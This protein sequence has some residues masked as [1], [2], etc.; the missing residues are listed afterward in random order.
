M[1]GSEPIRCADCKR[2]LQGDEDFCPQCGLPVKPARRLSDFEVGRIA[3]LESVK[4]DLW[5]RFRRWGLV[6]TIV[7]ALL[8]WVGGNAIISNAARSAVENR[9][10]M[11]ENRIEQTRYDLTLSLAHTEEANKRLG[12][13]SSK[14]KQEIENLRTKRDEIA[15]S[16]EEV[17]RDI[18]ILA[19]DLKEAV[20]AQRA[21]VQDFVG[22]ERRARLPSPC[23]SWPTVAN[24]TN[25]L[26]GQ[27]GT[28]PPTEGD[29]DSVVAVVRRY[30]ICD[31]Q[32]L[33]VVLASPRQAEVRELYHDILD[34]DPDIY[35]EIIWGWRLDHGFSKQQ[36]K[37]MIEESDEARHLSHPQGS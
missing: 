29:V 7:I 33:S 13:E 5:E 6:V 37:D 24:V 23:P 32:A 4:E 18:R 9:L 31:L 11:L 21:G 8:V 34:R 2:E 25:W 22:L 10:Q 28:R 15:K 26:A 14:L 20:M 16:A 27:Q 17:G 12:E 1:Q 19:V 3:A 35:G 30:N 36:V